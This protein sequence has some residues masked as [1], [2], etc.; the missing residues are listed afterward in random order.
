MNRKGRGLLFEKLTCFFIVAIRA[1]FAATFAA[2]T[3][4]LMILF[5]EDNISHIVIFRI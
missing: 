2:V 1:M 4:L 5:G 3:S